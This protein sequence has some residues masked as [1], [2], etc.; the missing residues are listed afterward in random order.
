[1]KMKVKRLKRLYA[2]IAGIPAQRI[3][4]SSWR[5]DH[6]TDKELLHDCGT[7]ACA[8]GWACAYPPFQK[9]GLAWNGATPVYRDREVG[10]VAAFE[11]AALFFGLSY[12]D[13]SELFGG[14]CSVYDDGLTSPEWSDK[15]LFLRRLRTFLYEG[16]VI[17]ERRNQELAKYEETLQ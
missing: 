13:A 12:S 8:L 16:E 2:V 9:K 1:M 10:L 3:K 11:A 17:S 6:A 15:Y 7:L 14:R 4:L 5:S